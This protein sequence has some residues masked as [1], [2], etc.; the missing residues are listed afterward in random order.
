M[1][2]PTDP[3]G[4]YHYRPNPAGYSKVEVELV[5]G[6]YEDLELDYPGGD[7]ETHLRDTSHT[8]IL[9]RRRYIILPG[10]QA[11]SRAPSPPAPPSP[12]Q[13]PAPSPPHAPAPSPPQ[14]PAPTPPHAPALSPPQAPAPTPPQAPAPTPPRAPTPTPPQAPLPAP[15]KSKAP[16]AP[17]PAHTRAMKKAKV[18]AAKNKDPGYDCT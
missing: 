4:T 16:Q 1:A 8:I 18:D 10:R 7:G 9:W 11:A 5:E 13:D 6:A 17:P 3:L 15:S 2:I 12:P 14:A